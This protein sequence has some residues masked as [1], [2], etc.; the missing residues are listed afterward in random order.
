MTQLSSAVYSGTESATVAAVA[1]DVDLV[2]LRPSYS[3]SDGG[4]GI[5]KCPRQ[6]IINGS[7]DLAIEYR[8]GATDTIPVTA[9]FT[10]NLQP[11]KMLAATT[12][13]N[14]TVVW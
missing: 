2:A 1:A 6:L 11:S 7:G 9:P 4:D 5:E 14:I 12:C 13:T 8:S 3:K 10:L